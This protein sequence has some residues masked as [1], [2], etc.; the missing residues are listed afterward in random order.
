VQ[1]KQS[2][3]LR[4]NDA[5]HRRPYRQSS[6]VHHGATALEGVKIMMLQTKLGVVGGALAFLIFGVGSA[7]AH[8]VYEA[9][10]T[11]YQRGFSDVRLERASLPYSFNACR[12]GTRYHIHV[13]YYGNLEEVD[14]IGP[15]YSYGNG[16]RNGYGSRYGNGYEYEDRRGY[17]GGN[18]YRGPDYGRRV[19]YD[20]RYR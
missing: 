5:A 16:Y 20:D 9:E 7:S 10:Q 11:L 17:Y 4:A 12:G 8:S 13:D 19:P 15:C 18:R 1:Y 3:A 2:A 14:P 6:E